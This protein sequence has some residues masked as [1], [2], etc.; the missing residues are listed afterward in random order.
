MSNHNVLLSKYK[1]IIQ[2]PEQPDVVSDFINTVKQCDMNDIL[3]NSNLLWGEEQEGA[4]LY[5][6]IVSIFDI[7]NQELQSQKTKLEQFI[8]YCDNRGL[9]KNENHKTELVDALTMINFKLSNNDFVYESIS[10]IL[11]SFCNTSTLEK[12]YDEV[13]YEIDD[14]IIKLSNNDN[15]SIEKICDII[16]KCKEKDFS[17]MINRLIDKSFSVGIYGEETAVV[18]TDNIVTKIPLVLTNK[19]KGMEYVDPLMVE[20]I[21][22]KIEIDRLM[23][24]EQFCQHTQIIDK[25]ASLLHESI[26]SVSSNILECNYMEIEDI[27]SIE[28]KAMIEF[29]LISNENSTDEYVIERLN[30]IISLSNKYN[31]VVTEG[32][33]EKTLV[34]GAHKAEKGVTKLTHSVKNVT[35]STGNVV[36]AV[37]QI[38][39]ALENEISNFINKLIEKDA[40]KRREALLNKGVR[41][42]LFKFIRKSIG[43]TITTSLF[44]PLAAAIGYIGSIAVDKHLDAKERRAILREMNQELTILDEKIDDAK[45][46]GDNKQKY[47]LMRLKDKLENERKRVQF[48]LDK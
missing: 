23:L 44:G 17:H 18:D 27:R 45:A 29:A 9:W 7:P 12:N 41:V 19:F 42:R 28:M 30:N 3:A 22:K 16:S 48:L 21:K 2:H 47:Q 39:K 32:K 36:K 20:C 25:I 5:R 40:S 4:R 31:E 26:D 38:P 35:T 34:R 46:A 33:I 11:D 13:M 14:C 24:K 8:S 15:S 1:A 37:G 6:V 43:V 10:R